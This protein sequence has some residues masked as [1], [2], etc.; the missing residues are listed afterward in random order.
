MYVINAVMEDSSLLEHDAVSPDI[1]QWRFTSK[2][3]GILCYATIIAEKLVKYSSVGRYEVK[4]LDF[5]IA[6]AEILCKPN[7]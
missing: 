7:I 4:Y 3:T 5:Q 2:K 6:T 1:Q